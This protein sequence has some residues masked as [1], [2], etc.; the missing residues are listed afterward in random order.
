VPPEKLL[1]I[2]ASIVRPDKDPTR[3]LYETRGWARGVE[4]QLPKVLE[5]EK[6]ERVCAICKSE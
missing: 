4:F 3:C 5:I 2:V 1:L 6:I